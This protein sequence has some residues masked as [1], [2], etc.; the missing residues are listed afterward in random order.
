MDEMTSPIEKKALLVIVLYFFFFFF[1]FALL[2]FD[3]FAGYMWMI[4]SYNGKILTV[5]GFSAL[6]GIGYHLYHPV[7]LDTNDLVK[8]IFPDPN[9]EFKL[10]NTPLLI[11]LAYS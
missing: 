6:K 9:S 8:W 11:M 4:K 10:L 5:K 7:V 3:Y 1:F 2:L